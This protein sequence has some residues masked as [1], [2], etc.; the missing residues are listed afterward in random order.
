MNYKIELAHSAS[1]GY[2]ASFEDAKGLRFE[3]EAI[4]LEG[5]KGKAIEALAEAAR[6][7]GI[8]F[9]VLP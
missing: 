1:G 5:A 7:A 4:T 9:E 8:E 2:V 6:L 3:F